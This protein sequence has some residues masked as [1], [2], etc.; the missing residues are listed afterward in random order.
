MFGHQSRE[1]K[2]R[3]KGGVLA[4]ATVVEESTRFTSGSNHENGRYIVGTSRNVTLLLQV[5]PEGQPP[6]EVK[7]RQT[8]KHHQPGKGWRVQVIYDPADPADL[9]VIEEQIIPPGITPEQHARSQAHRAEARAA[10]ESGHFAEYIEKRK[11]EALASP[12]TSIVLGAGGA[13]SNAV[14]N[15]ADQLERLADLRD[16]GVLTDPEFAAQKAKLLG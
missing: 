15:V 2:L 13:V 11:A 6:F 12:G 14:P 3:A 8:F 7:L 1:E 16:R 5:E 9:A 10:M 4:W